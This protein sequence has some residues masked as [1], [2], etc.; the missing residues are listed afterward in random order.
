MKKKAPV[1]YAGP[2]RATA[3]VLFVVVIAGCASTRTQEL[4]GSQRLALEVRAILGIDWPSE[5][6]QRQRQ[7]LLAMGP[8][9]DSIL[10]AVAQDERARAEARADALDILAERQSPVALAMLRSALQDENEKLRS[11]AVLGLNRLAPNS[12][13]A[14]ELI[15]LAAEDRSRTVRL[16]ALQSLDISEVQTIRGVLERETDPEV[17]EV[18]FQLVSL[19]E[20]RGASLVPDQE[21]TLR[22][23][24]S[25]TEP[26]IVFRPVRKEEFA[27]VSFGELRVEI[28]NGPDIPLAHNAEVVA[29]VV[30]AFFSPD[31]GDIVAEAEGEIRVIHLDSRHV[32]SLGNGLAP[33]LIPF[34]QNFVFLRERADSQISTA[35]GMAVTYDVYRAGF[36]VPDVEHIGNLRAV[37]KSDVNAGESPVRWMVV[38]EYEEGF[39]LRGENIETFPLPT[40]VWNTGGQHD[41]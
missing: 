3:V 7:R 32:R 40:P 24:S 15:R 11:A 29:N 36:H 33:R 30:P 17:R 8:E 22:T 37:T 5:E 13:P 9:I 23:A 14:L 35:E 1:R 2:V 10:V 12:E 18:A 41:R 28:P 16:N 25:D 26:Q 6:Y 21:G 39:A 27:N 34:S 38:G 4:Q 19:A 31:R 20:A